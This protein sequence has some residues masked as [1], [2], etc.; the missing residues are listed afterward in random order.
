[1]FLNPNRLQDASPQEVLAAAAQGHI[2]LDQRFVHALT[3]RTEQALPAVVEWA[4]RDRTNDPVDLAP[5]LI[6]LFRHW[7]TADAIPFLIS[8]I[9][10]DPENVPDEA[11]ETL[12]SL[13]APALEPL[14]KL[15][16][17]LDEKE[18]A[19]VAFML[20]SLRIR[21]QRILRI[22]TDRLEFD[23]TDA[24]FLLSIYGDPAAIPAVDAAAD[25][26]GKDQPDLKRELLEAKEALST[27]STGIEPADD[28]P[29][30]IYELYPPEA[31]LPVDSL[32][33]D[34]RVELLGHAEDHVRAAAANSFFNQELSGPLRK[35]MLELATTDASDVVRA[36]AWESLMLVTEDAAVVEAMLAA[37]RKPDLSL[38]ERKG[39]IVGLS[40]EADRNEVRAGIDALYGEAEG[41]AKA[42]EAMWRSMHASFRD[43][44]AKHLSDPDLEVRRSAIWG[45]GY[46]GIRTEMEKLRAM[47]DDEEL[48]S[49]ALFA[50]TLALPG[51]V[52]R[53]RVKGMLTKVEKDARGLSE[54]EEEL[55]KTALD[56]KLM[57]A[58]KE[59]FFAEQED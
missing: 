36:R 43:R 14:L 46:F 11:L 24:A 38:E 39:L 49:D 8:Y 3:D 35:R 50:Y 40:A 20:A 28:E 34:E 29:F 21:D 53:G 9:E 58:G 4:K 19:E 18:S 22:L 37:L 45:V 12:A 2:G 16:E 23:V 26:V 47:F 56:E 7:K 30:D 51:E 15:Y 27:G 1:M 5:E 6:A 55:V 32:D 52:S 59:P 25:Q 42:L 17:Q 54:M 10:E 13:G 33:E 44:F 41:R 57:L 48:R 31:D